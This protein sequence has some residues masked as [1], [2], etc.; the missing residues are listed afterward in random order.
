MFDFEVYYI[1]RKKYTAIDSLSQRPTTE[2]KR[3][4]EA[5]EGNINNQLDKLLFKDRTLEFGSNRVT[6]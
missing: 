1:P 5:I 4:E 6:T 2:A 3:E